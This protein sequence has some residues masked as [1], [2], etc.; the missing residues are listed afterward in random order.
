MRVLRSEGRRLLLMVMVMAMLAGTA[1]GRAHSRSKNATLWRGDD[2]TGRRGKT[3][4]GV[5]DRLEE[6]QV[7]DSGVLAVGAATAALV[8]TNDLSFDQAS[9]TWNWRHSYCESTAESSC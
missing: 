7:S 6:S 1:L 9:S 3:L 5:D 8:R 4:Y 2:F